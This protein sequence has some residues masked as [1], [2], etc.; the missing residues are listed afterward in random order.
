MTRRLA[1][2]G[3]FSARHLER[4]VAPSVVKG[5]V[6]TR[7]TSDFGGRT[8]GGC[9]PFNATQWCPLQIS[10]DVPPAY[11][12][13]GG[14]IGFKAGEHHDGMTKVCVYNVIGKLEAIRIGSVD[15]CP[16]S[17]TF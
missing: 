3:A 4:T 7:C 11:S 8:P 6:D 12:S 10:D 14:T 13:G 2:S 17:H 15:V 16:M 9:T 5:G 1:Q